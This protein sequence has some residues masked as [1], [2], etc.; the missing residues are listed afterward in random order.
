M[1]CVDQT[2]TECAE[3][4]GSLRPVQGPFEVFWRADVIGEH[5]VRGSQHRIRKSCIFRFSRLLRDSFGAQR[6]FETTSASI[7][8]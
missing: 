3:P 2:D 7:V 1:W 4:W 5:V 6:N 8:R